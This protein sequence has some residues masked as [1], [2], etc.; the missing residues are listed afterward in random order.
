MKRNFVPLDL[1]DFSEENPGPAL[2]LVT[3][4]EWH[5]RVRVGSTSNLCPVCTLSCVYDD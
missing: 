2:V 3:R 1:S 5:F 4:H